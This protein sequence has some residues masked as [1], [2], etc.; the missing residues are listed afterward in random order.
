[1]SRME[2]GALSAG[3]KRAQGYSCRRARDLRH[4]Q[5][6]QVRL[7]GALGH[8][9][10]AD[11]QGPPAGLGPDEGGQ[12]RAAPQPGEELLGLHALEAGKAQHRP[13]LPVA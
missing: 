4:Q 5:L 2:A 1:M 8:M 12:L 11:D 7:G 13:A 6:G 9:D 10:A 3:Q